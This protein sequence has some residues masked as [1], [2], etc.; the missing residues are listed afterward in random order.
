MKSTH[1]KMYNHLH[2]VRYYTEVNQYVL[3]FDTWMTRNIINK[4]KTKTVSI[5]IFNL[6][7]IHAKTSTNQIRNIKITIQT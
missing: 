3:H 7:K 5:A 4:K 1:C 6:S 2:I